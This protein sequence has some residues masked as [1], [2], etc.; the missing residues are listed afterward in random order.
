MEKNQQKIPTIAI[1]GRP[2]VGKSTLF[3]RLARKRLAIVDDLPGVTRDRLYSRMEW[4]GKIYNL[5]DTGGWIPE[6]EGELIEELTEQVELAVREADAIIFLLDA[7]DGVVEG[8]K[9]IA[10]QL[11]RIKK[12]VF[13]AV[14]KIDSRHQEKLLW[15]FYQLGAE[16][17]FPISALHNR[18]IDQL[19]EAISQTLPGA[20]MEILEKELAP[21]IPRIAVIGRP[22]VGKSS[23]INRI[24]G[25]ERLLVTSEPGTT[26]DA[27]DTEIEFQGK[28]Y[29][30]IDTAGM[31][32][33][34]KIDRK[35]ERISV[36]RAV[37]AIERADI[38]LLMVDATEGPTDQD[39][40]L[41]GLFLRRAKAGIV[42]LNKWDLVPKP[43][44]SLSE[45]ESAV[46]TR[47]WHIAFAPVLPISAKTGFGLEALFPTIDKVFEQY[48]RRV[49]TGELNRKLERI[50][51]Q[52][53]LPHYQGKPLKVYYATQA[54]TRPPLFVFFVNYP[55]AIKEP[56]KRFL[57]NRLI[58]EFKFFGTPLLLEF[59]AK[60][61]PDFKKPQK[62]R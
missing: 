33:K 37:K 11:R 35:L 4:Q 48:N 53:Q 15:E 30:F 26:R 9:M 40:K 61:K 10:D 5:I 60:S 54:G 44:V 29:L 43:E 39:A 24:L 55:Q 56:F 41:A 59:R 57:H 27:V 1:V 32:R 18:G 3:N 20:D 22:N 34:S 38:I 47:L 45:I 14:N 16:E 50:L 62:A 42:L 28:K 7:R 2:N 12:P 23:L 13:Y 19:M 17:I 36:L 51:T 31:R 8:D 58:K 49:S 25:Q 46:K 52:T 21:E 6:A